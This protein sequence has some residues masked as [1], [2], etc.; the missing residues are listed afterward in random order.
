LTIYGSEIVCGIAKYRYLT[1]VEL[2]D[3]IV[4]QV[5]SSLVQELKHEASLQ[6]FEPLQSFMT[7]CIPL[8]IGTSMYVLS[9]SLS[10]KLALLNGLNVIVVSLL[11]FRN[12]TSKHRFAKRMQAS[13]RVWTGSVFL[14]IAIGASWHFYCTTP[15][16]THVSIQRGILRTLLLLLL[17]LPLP[18]T[19]KAAAAAAVVVVVV[20]KRIVSHADQ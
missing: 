2:G 6:H 16:S 14:V 9:L 11:W 17:L 4:Q 19:R 7:L 18:T 20:V 3:A 15:T 13:R 10:L 1:A 8:A 5:C 12:A